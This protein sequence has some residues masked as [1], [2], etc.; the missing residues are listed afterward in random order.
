MKREAKY[1]ATVSLG[2][3]GA[4][5]LATLP[6]AVSSQVWGSFLQGGF[7]AG[8][9]G[10]LAD[11]FAVSALFRHP[12]GIPIPHTALLPNNREKITKALVNTVQ[13]ELLSKETIRARLE[14]IHFLERGLEL[15][16]KQ[17]DN[18][19]LHTGLTALAKHALGAIDIE[20][21]TP[22]L[23]E[24]IHKAI[25][26]VD[27]S[28]LVRTLIDSITD[29]DY[30]GKTLDFVLDKAAAWVIK[31]D[32]RDQLGAMAIKAFE[33]LAS[34]GFMA[35]AVNAFMGM[36][37]EEK[38][39]GIIQNFVLSYIDQLR[40]NHHP[41]RQAVLTFIRNEL[42]KLD[43]NPQLLAELEKFKTKLPEL[44]DLDAKLTHMLTKLKERGEA[45][46]DQPEFVPVHVVPILRNMLLS[47]R[48][49][50]DMLHRGEDWIQEQ[51]ASY[52]EQNHSKIGQL[53]KENLD[54]LDNAK[55]TELMEEKVGS[56]LQWIRV[57]GA[58]CG[59]IIGLGLAGLKMLF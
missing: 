16:D 41:R 25:Q 37:N 56:D 17:L 22:L 39:G 48:E 4:G 40:M 32:T 58:I 20:K 5:F 38:L 55:L 31:A 59:F 1:I 29:N 34:N 12:L 44:F 7:E 28:R 24:E 54:K 19:S 33:G 14:K 9:V 49:N 52:L 36:V 21:L 6:T 46:I 50:Q 35:F 26:D 45:F 2:V 13:N 11:W 42:H 8:V 23:A 3:M 30:D 53:V 57:N 51:I 18:A 10:G 43:R 15:A 27:T 47:I